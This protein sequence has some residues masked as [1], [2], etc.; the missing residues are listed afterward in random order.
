MFT[1]SAGDY[2]YKN[3]NKVGT[4]PFSLITANLSTKLL[5]F[6]RN[7]FRYCVDEERNRVVNTQKYGSYCVHPL[8]KAEHYAYWS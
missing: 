6:H 2:T 3:K 8:G 7:L 1:F 5:H 4:N